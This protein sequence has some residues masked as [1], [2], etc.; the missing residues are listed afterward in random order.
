[1]NTSVSKEL[2]IEVILPAITNAI[3]F[4]HLADGKQSAWGAEQ[5]EKM[6]LAHFKLVR[7][8]Y[9]SEEMRATQYLAKSIQD[10][11]D[12]GTEMVRESLAK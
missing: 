2:I 5:R 9:R 7:K 3:R 6:I 1:M 4:S 12:L 10:G 11:T 8:V